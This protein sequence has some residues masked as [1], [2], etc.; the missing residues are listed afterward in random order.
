MLGVADTSPGAMLLR[1]SHWVSTAR[2]P[3][4]FGKTPALVSPG[5]FTEAFSLS[6]LHFCKL[7]HK[8]AAHLV[9][10][11]A[12]VRKQMGLLC[13]LCVLCASQW[14]ELLPCWLAAASG[15]KFFLAFCHWLFSP[16]PTAF[17]P[18]MA[19][20]YYP[21]SSRP[22]TVNHSDVWILGIYFMPTLS[23]VF[24]SSLLKDVL[25]LKHKWVPQWDILLNSYLVCHACACNSTA[26][27]NQGEGVRKGLWGLR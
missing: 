19:F 27:G 16:F 18:E 17:S 5:D 10:V 12:C 6:A 8:S 14:V 1:L 4:Q 13:A 22:L 11:G 3:R 2:E 25:S 7:G 26:Q 24:L 21:W 9:I 15:F 20:P 23:H